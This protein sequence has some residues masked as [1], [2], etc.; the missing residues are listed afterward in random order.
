[1][2]T[3]YVLSYRPAERRWR[4]RYQG[5]YFNFPLL[6]GETKESSYQRVKR[7]W[8]KA[9]AEFDIEQTGSNEAAVRLSWSP[10]VNSV[11]EAQ[12]RLLDDY[13]DTEET[14][15]IF[16]ALE[17]RYIHRLVNASIVREEAATESDAE[18]H[19]GEVRETANLLKQ[20]HFQLPR[21]F[22][23]NTKT[24]PPEAP[25][26]EP[27]WE[28]PQTN[29]G[30]VE[31]RGLADCFIESLRV[32]ASP[33][34]AANVK[35]EVDRFLDWLPA[36]SSLEDA[37]KSGT[38]DSFLVHIKAQPVAPKTQSDRVAGVKQFAL[39]LYHREHIAEIPRLI[40]S[41][42]FSIEV[43]DS[44]ISIFE[45]SEV[46]A[47]LKA[48]KDRP[49]LYILLGL[50]CGFTQIDIAD[51]KRSEV[52][53]ENGTIQ[54]KRSKTKHHKT[55]PTVT[56]KLWPET[57]LLLR[58]HATDVEKLVLLNVNG[59]PLVGVQTDG[60]KVNRTDAVAKSMQRLRKSMKRSQPIA[61]KTF[62]KTAASKLGSNDD[63]ARWADYFLGHAPSTTAEKAYVRPNQERFD[64][65]I[66]W[67]RGQFVK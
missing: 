62:R 14:R 28:S 60:V 53:F 11:R 17:R 23:E 47:I 58:E 12:Q 42:K 67:L 43:G 63:F 40:A 45:D 10:V 24:A 39:W 64:A 13:G 5:R 9:K 51:L 54:R 49:R 21:K 15:E 6:E 44:E 37:M 22:F 25:P 3:K 46:E 65:A 31:L 7:E 48:A 61:F 18:F 57:L 36:E 55:V 1:M 33:R 56:Y 19:I 29:N 34:R 2:A 30:L 50:N 8:L 16:G 26:S 4:K 66:A 27:P 35:R 52:D 20:A 32:D 41:R 38:L 59:K